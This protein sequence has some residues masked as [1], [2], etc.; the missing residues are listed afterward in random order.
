M[1]SK[2][3]MLKKCVELCANKYNFNGEEA[4]LMIEREMSKKRSSSE[5]S[6]VVKSSIPL[7][8]NGENNS[9]K[10]FGLMK[11][12]GLYTQ[13]CSDRKNGEAYC[14][15]CFK[16]ASKNENGLSD[17]GH[18][19]NRTR[20]YN[21]N[22]EYVDPSGKKPIAY[23][24]VM[25]KLKITEEQVLAEALR[26]GVKLDPR[27]FLS[28]KSGR[29]VKEKVAKKEESAAKKGR[30]KKSKKVLELAGEED[31][32][33][34]LVMTANSS[35]QRLEKVEQNVDEVNDVIEETVTVEVVSESVLGDVVVEALVKEVKAKAPKVPKVKE[36]SEEQKAAKALAQQEKEQKA[37]LAEQKKIE[38]EQKAALA[39]QKK[40]E[41]EQ[42][43]ALAEQKK[44]EKEQKAAL[45]EQKKVEK[46]QKAALAE[47]KKVEKEQKAAL[48]EQKK[49]EKEQKVEKKVAEKKQ[50]NKTNIDDDDRPTPVFVAPPDD[51]DVVK[52]VTFEG[53]KYLKSKNTGIIYNMEQDVIGK[54]NEEK[55]RI[56]FDEE[57]EE[58]EDEYD[59]DM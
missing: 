59:E 49:V 54:W 5:S 20:C 8:Y 12:H 3:E 18:I 41:K 16:Q 37:A 42:K 44:V 1:S 19:D 10:C 24:K 32:F 21:R 40:V 51:T 33:A 2:S 46:E 13:C 28:K 22:E 31:L 23:L 7:P 14:G 52:K 36:L 27:H 55:Q 53:K 43:A 50:V 17:Y 11:N 48:A 38:K 39:E 29:P 58:S 9:G 57:G 4:L 35:D 15:K 34:S 56:D 6:S 25:K 26:Q 47:Q 30:P 45:A